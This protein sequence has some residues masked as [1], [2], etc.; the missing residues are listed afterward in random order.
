MKQLSQL[1]RTATTVAALAARLKRWERRLALLEGAL[2]L[3]LRLWRRT[4]QQPRGNA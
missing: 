1:Q 3:S 4:R 2:R